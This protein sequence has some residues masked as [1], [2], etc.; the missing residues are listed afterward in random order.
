MNVEIKKMTRSIYLAIAITALALLLLFWLFSRSFVSIKVTPVNAKVLVDDK[1]VTVTNGGISRQNVTPG[2]HRVT[3][4]ADNFIGYTQDVD[5]KRGFMRQIT[6]SLV[7]IPQPLEIGSGSKL[8]S[9]GKDFDVVNYL[10]SDSK[11]LYQAKLGTN[12]RG[13][14]AV[15]STLAITDPKL[16]SISQIIWSPARDVALFRKTD[17][18]INIFDFMKYDFIHQT[19]TAWGNNIASVAW[20]PDSSEVT[21]YYTGGGEQSLILSNIANTSVTRVENF[22]GTNIVNPL[23][24]WSPDSQ[25]LLIIPQ[26]SDVSK[27]N[28]YVFD[29]YARTMKAI[30]DTGN[31]VDANFSPD[32]NMILYST[33]SKDSVN[34][35]TSMLSVMDKD[36]SNQRSLDLRAEVSKVAWS[37]DSKNIAVATYDS[38]TQ[39]ESIFNFNTVTKT[40]E[41]FLIKDLGD[42]FIKSLV[43][44]DDGKIVIY[45]TN[46][47]IFALKVE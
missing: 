27:N 45:E 8:L 34:P 13:D 46:S 47:G 20:A 38:G 36:G 22:A 14:L 19:E 31:I 28:L 29:A 33:Y 43:I 24:R 26:N 5:F 12:D 2:I 30:T 41:G 21:Y 11:T 35:V 6:V 15:L 9:K 44:S 4:S 32:G 18:T 23:L 17:N 42:I 1:V 39:K 25:H 37:S 40:Q 3:I 7:A 10:S 16:A